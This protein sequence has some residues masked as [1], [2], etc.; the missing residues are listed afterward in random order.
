MASVGGIQRVPSVFVNV[1]GAE[2]ARHMHLGDRS[3]TAAGRP[4]TYS[5]STVSESQSVRTTP[6]RRTCAFH[7]YSYSKNLT[8]MRVGPFSCLVCLLGAS[9]RGQVT[10]VWLIHAAYVRVSSV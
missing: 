7:L 4:V 1:F 8:T 9:S 5:W 3:L 2:A 10:S 6:E